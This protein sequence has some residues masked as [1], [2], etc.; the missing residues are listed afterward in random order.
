MP[1]HPIIRKGDSPAVLASFGVTQFTHGVSG[2]DGWS[3][4]EL[5][6]LCTVVQEELDSIRAT[7]GVDIAHMIPNEIPLYAKSKNVKPDH[8]SLTAVQALQSQSYMVGGVQRLRMIKKTPAAFLGIALGLEQGDLATID[9]HR[10]AIRHEL[11]HGVT[12]NSI[13]INELLTE[14]VVETLSQPP[15]LQRTHQT[16]WRQMPWD[17]TQ[18]QGTSGLRGADFSMTTLV[19]T[20]QERHMT[21][22]L[23]RILAVN[24]FR[25][26]TRDQLWAICKELHAF[27]MTQGEYPGF[28]TFADVVRAVL[29]TTDATKLLAQ[30]LFQPVQPGIQSYLLPL[31]SPGSGVHIQSVNIFP[32]QDYE[33]VYPNGATDLRQFAFG[34]APTIANYRV[35][36]RSGQGGG[37]T[38]SH[39]GAFHLT[40]PAVARMLQGQGIQVAEKQIASVDCDVRGMKTRL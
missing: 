24:A 6:A 16:S 22:I 31:A 29:P 40:K 15:N 35:A 4:E 2:L 19:G 7:T 39:P 20:P 25:A 38:V 14:G 5:A 9:R 37:L 23:T 17:W 1:T 18:F 28:N 36:T 33:R 11:I 32:N 10:E 12:S 34:P 21:E 3:T 8:A 30:H 13:E 27:T 26:Q